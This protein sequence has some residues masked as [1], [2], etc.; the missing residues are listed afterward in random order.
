MFGIYKNA[1]L[2]LLSFVPAYFRRHFRFVCFVS[3][4]RIHSNCKRKRLNKYFREH[5]VLFIP[6]PEWRVVGP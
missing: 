2:C 6:D 1:F 5:R 4:F 3:F